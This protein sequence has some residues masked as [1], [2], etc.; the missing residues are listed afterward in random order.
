M[1]ITNGSKIISNDTSKTSYSNDPNVKG[2]TGKE[3]PKSGA[4]RTGSMV[5]FTAPKGSLLGFASIASIGGPGT[6]KPECTGGDAHPDN[7]CV[8][9]HNGKWTHYDELDPCS[10]HGEGIDPFSL[11]REC[12]VLDTVSCEVCG[13]C[14]VC[15]SDGAGGFSCDDIPG[16]SNETLCLE[17]DNSA[18]CGAIANAF[19]SKCDEDNP[20]CCDGTCLGWDDCC[21][22]FPA[23]SGSFYPGCPPFTCSSC[24]FGVCQEGGACGDCQ[25]CDT[26]V[27]VDDPD[28]YDSEGNPCYDASSLDIELMP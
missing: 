16:D 25:K 14:Y 6:Y 1:R 8:I 11:L 28:G 20:K 22:E 24:E 7:M 23:M 13:P 12:L 4:A 3:L 27:C 10:I 19:S 21:Y 18:G 17:C 5:S 15:N 26:G 2:V 9:C